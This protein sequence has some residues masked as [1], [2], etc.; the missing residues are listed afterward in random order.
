LVA[1]IAIGLVNV[2]AI[3]IR[4]SI[5]PRLGPEVVLPVAIATPIVL[6]LLIGRVFYGERLNGRAWAGCAIAVAAIAAL[7]YAAGMKQH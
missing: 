1:G 6:V 2:T 7:G 3:P 5:M 4:M